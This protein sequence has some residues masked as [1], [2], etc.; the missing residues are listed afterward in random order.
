MAESKAQAF[1]R[2]VHEQLLQV[3]QPHF[4]IAYQLYTAKER[5]FPEELGYTDIYELSEVEFGFKRSSTA[6]YISVCSNYMRPSNIGPV[7]SHVMPLWAE[8]SFSQLVEMLSLDTYVRLRIKPTMTVRQIRQYRQDHKFV[9]LSDGRTLMYGSLTASEKKDYETLKA[10]KQAAKQKAKEV[11][12]QQSE[13]ENFV[14]TS[15]QADC[16][17][18]DINAFEK[19]VEVVSE[20]AVPKAALLGLKNRSERETWL[21]KYKDWGVWMSVPELEL[22][23]YKYVFANGD[24]LVVSESY[25]FD[26]YLV[27][28]KQLLVRYH[29][30][31]AERPFFDLAGTAKTYVLNY[32]TEHGREL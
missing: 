20:N 16:E 29:L 8:F 28:K 31:N 23:L 9:T 15:G 18:A 11:I 26:S 1:V 30:K 32:M 10:E 3:K 6:A 14:Q 21:D 25:Y 19:N 5:N 27:D 13:V 7:S 2:T 17:T 22:T 4:D 12:E 24:E